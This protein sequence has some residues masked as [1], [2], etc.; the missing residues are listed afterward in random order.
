[1]QNRMLGEAVEPFVEF[2]LPSIRTV[3]KRGGRLSGRGRGDRLQFPAQELSQSKAGGLGS[4]RQFGFNFRFEFQ[5][6]GHG[7]LCLN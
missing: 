6:N 7:V 5:G 2:A 4:R 3:R 1:M